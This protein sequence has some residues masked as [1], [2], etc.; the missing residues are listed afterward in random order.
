MRS[1]TQRGA[2]TA[3]SLSTTSFAIAFACWG[4]VA[5]LAPLF[6][7]M[8]GLTDTEK[9]IL[10]AI[11]VLLGS[12]GRIPIGMLAD[13]F[14]GRIVLTAVLASS[15]VAAFAL[16]L[17]SSYQQMLWVGFALGIAG[18]SFSVGVA[19][20]S[21]WFPPERQ[22]FAL[23]V[24]GAGNI[25][26]SVAIFFAPVLSGK[27]GW[28]TTYQVFA[29][30]TAVWTVA[31]FFV[32]RDAPGKPPAKTMRQVFE[33]MKSGMAWLLSLFYFVTFGCFVAMSVY[34]PSLLRELYGLSPADAGLRVA[35]YILLATAMRPVGGWLSD[36]IGAARILMFVF[37][38][39]MA[40]AP[41]MA[42][43]NMLSFT[44]GALGIAAAIGLGNGAVFKLV[45]QY[46]PAQV[47]AVTGLVGAM[48]GLGGF[49][50]PIYM[51]LIKD[52]TGNYALGFFLLA[53][54][55]EVCLVFNYLLLVR[56][57]AQREVAT[58]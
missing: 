12:V 3:L 6:K 56:Q 27:Y 39:V 4:L 1:D 33:P 22:G 36:K 38:A 8:Y 15:A 31:F 9:S 35:G 49:F 2:T 54:I 47:G 5:A 52:A 10:I 29:A 37:A 45:P 13:R 18:T 28:Q 44:I 11:P 55:A 58:V 48:G 23:G 32:A 53:H 25:G 46:F 14:G 42:P 30:I 17:A 43:I 7:E 24:F 34:L 57:P 21:R 50:P 40:L 51:G 16:S 19:F 20:T 41:I 26:Q